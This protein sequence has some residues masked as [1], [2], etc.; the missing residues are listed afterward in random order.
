MNGINRERSYTKI[1]YI[2]I[3]MLAPSAE[4]QPPTI[5]SPRGASAAALIHR[6]PNVVPPAPVAQQFLR[7]GFVRLTPHTA[8]RIGL[9]RTTF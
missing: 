1:A 9:A 5:A 8:R 2:D 6:L 4:Y 7:I 3:E